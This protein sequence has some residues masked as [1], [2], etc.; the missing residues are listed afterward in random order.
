MSSGVRFPA[1]STPVQAVA[2]TEIGA[3]E[4]LWPRRGYDWQRVEEFSELYAADG[5]TALPPI[6]LVPDPEGGF[7][8]ADGWHR[9]AALYA[10]EAQNARAVVVTIPEGTDPAV[11]VFELAVLRSAISARPLTR[12]EKQD[13]VLR[14]LEIHPGASDREIG[15]WA[16]VDHKTVGRLRTWG[17]SPPEPPR[18]RPQPSPEEAARR[19]LRGFEAIRQARGLTLTD[20]LRG[21]DASGHRLAVVLVDLYG[22]EAP[23]RASAYIDALQQATAVIARRGVQS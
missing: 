9:L 4:E 6:E 11:A 23:D 3:D 13:A 15:R 20:L 12:A 18:S 10:L 5:L 16:G 14:L 17:I 2:L 8:L 22:E 7:L 21:G 19:L 1:S